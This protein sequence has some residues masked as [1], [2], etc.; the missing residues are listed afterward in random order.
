[1]HLLFVVC[2]HFSHIDNRLTINK[3]LPTTKWRRDRRIRLS[4]EYHHSNHEAAASAAAATATAVIGGGTTLIKPLGESNQSNSISDSNSMEIPL[5]M[6]VGAAT[7]PPPP[8]YRDPLPGSTFCTMSRPSVI[9]QAPKR[10][11]ISNQENKELSSPAQPPPPKKP[12]M[13]DD[14]NPP[15]TGTY[16][17][18]FSLAC[19]FCSQNKNLFLYKILESISM[20]DA[21]IDEH[22]RRSLGTLGGDYMNLFGKRTT[23]ER[24]N[25][26][27]SPSSAP[28]TAATTPIT[29]TNVRKSAQVSPIQVNSPESHAQKSSSPPPPP[30]TVHES[31]RPNETNDLKQNVDTPPKSAKETIAD[32]DVEMSVD[33]H[34]A[35]ALGDTWKQLQHSKSRSSPIESDHENES[36]N[37]NSKSKTND[38]ND[39]DIDDDDDDERPTLQ[40]DTSNDIE[41]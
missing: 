37:K 11:V 7:K 15:A 36:I 10:E 41:S 32:E 28:S 8:P 23:L 17:R 31:K 9:T 19:I 25:Q 13:C 5:D 16:G 4:S 33:D 39:G 24:L 1:M 12:S 14:I 27:K 35:K 38:D 2:S 34:F 6:S 20:I 18:H 30:A 26:L 22:F 40:I 21:V 3:E 29:P